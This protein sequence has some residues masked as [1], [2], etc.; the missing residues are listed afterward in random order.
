[1]QRRGYITFGTSSPSLNPICKEGGNYIVTQNEVIKRMVDFIQFWSIH[2]TQLVQH[3][4][5]SIF[6]I[7]F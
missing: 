4:P 7:Q 6:N 3:A 2:K 1:M 5:H